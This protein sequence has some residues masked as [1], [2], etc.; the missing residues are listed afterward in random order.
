MAGRRSPKTESMT[1]AELVRVVARLQ[2]QLRRT[3]RELEAVRETLERRVQAVKRGADRR[4]TAMM[5]EIATLRHH[6]ARAAQLERVLAER[7]AED[8]PEP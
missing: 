8:A 5:R 3:E 6:E 1:K 4:L 2:R 7:D